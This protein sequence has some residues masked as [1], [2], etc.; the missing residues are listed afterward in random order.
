M[1]GVH[2]EALQA[3]RGHH[4]FQAQRVRGWTVETVEGSP[5]LVVLVYQ[6]SGCVSAEVVWMDRLG[7]A[8]LDLVAAH[9]N[10][11]SGAGDTILG[12]LRNLHCGDRPIDAEVCARAGLIAHT[13]H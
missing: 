4:A 13:L 9:L 11:L 1:I 2:K 8:N 12:A 7:V 3:A 10:S 5:A 6:E